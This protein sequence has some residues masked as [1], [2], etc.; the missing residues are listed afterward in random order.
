M[1]GKADVSLEAFVEGVKDRDPDQPEFLQAVEEVVSSIGPAL[2]KHAVYRKDKIL[3]RMVEPERVVMFRVPWY[4][5][6]GELHINR[7]FRVQMNS[8]IGPYK[9]G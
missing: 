4:D 8:A 3:E 1:T 9:G 5:D 7:G 2:E 6:Q